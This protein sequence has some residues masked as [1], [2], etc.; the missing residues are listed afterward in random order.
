MDWGHKVCSVRRK[1][2]HRDQFGDSGKERRRPPTRF[3]RGFTSVAQ[4]ADVIG[5]HAN[6]GL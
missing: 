1:C 3:G 5:T 6:Y 2:L 4:M